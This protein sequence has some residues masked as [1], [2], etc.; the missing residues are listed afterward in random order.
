MHPLRR[1]NASLLVVLP[2]H[3]P[4]ETIPALRRE[5]EEAVGQT[6]LAQVIFDLQQAVFVDSSGIGLMVAAR[7][8]TSARGKH[9]YLYRPGVHVLKALGLVHL[10]DAFTIETSQDLDTLLAFAPQ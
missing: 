8:W 1:V 7:H 5:M 3:L 6:W 10:T 4:A 2:D 9:L